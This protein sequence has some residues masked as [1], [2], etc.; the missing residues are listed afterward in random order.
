MCTACFCFKRE[1][2]MRNGF[3][4][5]SKPVFA[6]VFSNGNLDELLYG[7]SKIYAC[8]ELLTKSY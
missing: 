3:I 2:S 5:L 8:P 1:P 6:S 7:N 4:R